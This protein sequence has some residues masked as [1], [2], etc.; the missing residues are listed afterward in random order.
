M[1]TRPTTTIVI[2]VTPTG[3]YNL[4]QTGQGKRWPT[5]AL[6]PCDGFAT[7]EE[8]EQRKSDI[9]SGRWQDA[10]PRIPVGFDPLN[11]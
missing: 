8:A 11:R 7:R 1:M 3:R 5:A 2:Y 4:D 6:G 9:E 10:A